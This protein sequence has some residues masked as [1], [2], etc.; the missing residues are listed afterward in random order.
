MAIPY[1]TAYSID[2][3]G[4]SRGS[5]TRVPECRLRSISADHTAVQVTHSLFEGDRMTFY[6]ILTSR[7]NEL[8]YMRPIRFYT[9]DDT[10]I[11]DGMIIDT[12]YTYVGS[13]YMALRVNAAG[14]WR[15]LARMDFHQPIE[16]DETWCVND[17]YRDLVRIANDMGMMKEA[18]YTYDITRIPEYNFYYSLYETPIG[19]DPN[20][21]LFTFN[22]VYDGMRTLTQYLNIA[23]STCT[24]E[25][26]LRVEALPRPGDV[27]RDPPHEVDPITQ[28][29]VIDH[30]YILPFP[31]NQDKEAAA[32]FKRFQLGAG[33]NVKRDYRQLA[34]DCYAVGDGYVTQQIRTHK[35]LDAGKVTSNPTIFNIPEE[36]QPL[37]SHYLRFT[38]VNP[39]F[40]PDDDGSIEIT[41]EVYD[42]EG[43]WV[44]DVTDKFY[45]DLSY[46]ISEG[47]SPRGKAVHYTSE[48][49]RDRIKTNGVVVRMGAWD[50]PIEVTIEEVTNDDPP[51]NTTIAGKSINTF[52]HAPKNIEG[53][54]LNSQSR[55]D[56]IAG[57]H[58]RLYHAPLH[59][60]YAPVLQRYVSY[61]NLIGN[62]AKFYSPYDVCLGNFV[63]TD[64]VYGF[65][66]K[67]V[68]Q[69]LMGR[70]HSYDWDYDDTNVYVVVGTYDVVVDDAKVVL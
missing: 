60:V 16:Y 23:S 29:D 40:V 13:D 47:E 64:N 48:R 3:D 26:G 30:I 67:H 33:Y 15:E 55:V 42:D 8:D 56:Y 2:E 54:W 34:N 21:T 14:W 59:Q 1:L 51:Y 9:A 44:E 22:N 35:I 39:S 17:I 32:T 70:Q 65:S 10:K 6:Q 49:S 36:D 46:D 68:T 41:F 58:C 19:T 62:T 50:P 69:Y 43:H 18:K 5:Y 11:F 63:I 38:I 12:E 53:M 25:F 27:A 28:S 31:I 61:N 4:S 20:K 45:V 66:G 7:D 52:G 37:A 24:Y 57:K